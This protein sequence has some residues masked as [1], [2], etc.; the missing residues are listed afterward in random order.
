[1][2]LRFFPYKL[3]GV[4]ANLSDDRV[5]QQLHQLPP[6]PPPVREIFLSL[7]DLQQ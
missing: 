2:L 1:M 3:L 4:S 5:S 7:C 6:S